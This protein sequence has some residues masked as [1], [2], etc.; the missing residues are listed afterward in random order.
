MKNEKGENLVE[1]TLEKILIEALKEAHI[2][3]GL[4]E[5]RVKALEERNR[6]DGK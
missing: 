1:I 6:N 4:L 2:K 5:L 3:L